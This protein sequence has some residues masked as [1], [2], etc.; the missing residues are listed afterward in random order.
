MYARQRLAAVQLPFCL[1]FLFPSEFFFLLL[2]L[3]STFMSYI[4]YWSTCLTPPVDSRSV[5]GSRLTAYLLFM[6]RLTSRTPPERLMDVYNASF[7]AEWWFVRKPLQENARWEMPSSLSVS[8]H[9]SISGWGLEEALC[10][11]TVMNRCFSCFL[12][13]EPSA[14]RQMLYMSLL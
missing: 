8:G 5:L 1:T 11:L 12:F 9:K 6:P 3:F 2:L 7:S 10:L 13:L 4:T 14:P